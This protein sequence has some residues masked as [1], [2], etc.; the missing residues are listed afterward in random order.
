MR[1]LPI[2]GIIGD[3]KQVAG[4][5]YHAYGDKYVR[6]I[7]E[8]AAAQPVGLF[9]PFVPSLLDVVDGLLFT[10]S[11]S[12][13]RPELWDGPPDT[14]GPFDDVRDSFSLPLIQAVIERKIPALFIC[15]GF[16]EL[17]VSLGG[18]LVPDLGQTHH[19]PRNL[20]YEERYAP[21]HRI[22]L[23]EG[24]PLERVFG[25]NNL[26]VNSL[27]YQALDRIAPSLSVE[28]RAAD[29]VA[30]IVMHGD[31]PFAVGVQWHCE[32]RPDLYVHHQRLLNAFGKAARDRRDQC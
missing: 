9:P 13:I 1:H 26:E 6:A 15:R 25:A 3:L 11:A 16:Q 10:G 8:F 12:N 29:G 2:I 27:H 4:M 14:P 22:E 28:A 19:A 31:H 17:N 21:F 23:R 24:S 20:D 18:T 30:E 32:Y 5:P 7:A